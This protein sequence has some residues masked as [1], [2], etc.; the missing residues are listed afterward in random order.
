MLVG[1]GSV[2]WQPP[3]GVPDHCLQE[4]EVRQYS[5]FLVADTSMP[6]G[7]GPAAGE[8][9]TELANYIFG[10]NDRWTAVLATWLH[11]LKLCHQETT[12]TRGG[13]TP[14]QPHSLISA[15]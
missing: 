14:A 8:G 7:R 11:A 15:N 5:P 1:S 4:Y 2:G 3:S 9:F 13:P 6:Q 12:S 10:G